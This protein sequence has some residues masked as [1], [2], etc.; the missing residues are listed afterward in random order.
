MLVV[1]GSS[2][3]AEHAV[4][5]VYEGTI[6]Q[7]TEGIPS[8]EDRFA[9]ELAREYARFLEYTHRSPSPSGSGFRHSGGSSRAAPA[10]GNAAWC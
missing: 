8:D 3:T 5:G 4:K 9:Q 10:D 6:G 1:I 7:L 2:F